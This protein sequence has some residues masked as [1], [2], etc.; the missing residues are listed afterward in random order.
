MEMVGLERDISARCNEFA[1]LETLAWLQK[2]ISPDIHHHYAHVVNNKFCRS[3]GVRE[4][5]PACLKLLFAMK[6][7]AFR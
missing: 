5:S 6:W 3:R 7:E 2:L 1:T 4:F